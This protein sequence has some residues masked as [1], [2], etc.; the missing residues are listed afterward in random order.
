MCTYIP[1]LLDPLPSSPSHPSRLPQST[2]LRSLCYSAAVLHVVAYLIDDSCHHHH[3]YFKG[4][5]RIRFWVNI[6]S[7]NLCICLCTYR[8]MYLSVSSLPF[9]TQANANSLLLS[10]SSATYQT[11]V[12]PS[13]S[14]KICMNLLP[15]GNLTSY[16][17][18]EKMILFSVESLDGWVVEDISFQTSIF[19][20]SLP[21]NIWYFIWIWMGHLS[22]VGP[23][24]NSFWEDSVYETIWL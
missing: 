22:C 17:E 4:S 5:P 7:I 24:V 2:E 3:H 10:D 19:T 18:E 20:N 23:W 8:C 6:C 21:F 15:C 16:L 11:Q 13:K 12:C 9:L 1:A 14:Q